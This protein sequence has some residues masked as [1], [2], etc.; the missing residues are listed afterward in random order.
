[1]TT[2]ESPVLD[3]D[4]LEDVEPSVKV[5]NITRRNVRNDQEYVNLER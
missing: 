2:T 3:G 1:M 5:V 4:L